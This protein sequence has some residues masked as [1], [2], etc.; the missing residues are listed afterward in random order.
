M[1]EERAQRG[2]VT[3]AHLDERIRIAAREQ[4]GIVFRAFGHHVFIARR[5]DLSQN[6]GRHV[7]AGTV[8]GYETIVATGVVDSMDARP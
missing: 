2:A 6:A 5:R 4:G 8:I 1:A 7:P 3:A